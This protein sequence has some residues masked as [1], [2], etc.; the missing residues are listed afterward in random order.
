MPTTSDDLGQP[1]GRDVRVERPRQ[2]LRHRDE[3]VQEPRSLDALELMRPGFLEACV[4]ADH[5]IPRRSR[6]QNLCRP[7]DGHHARADVDGDPRQLAVDLLALTG[8]EADPDSSPSP[9]TAATI[10]A[11][12]RNAWAGS[13]NVA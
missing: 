11:A 6:R 12:A 10:V 1:L 5:E 2:P 9:W 3:P 13:P 8:M 7:G 4:R